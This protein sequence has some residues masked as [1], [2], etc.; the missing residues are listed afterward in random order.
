MITISGRHIRNAMVERRRMKRCRPLLRTVGALVSLQRGSPSVDGIGH[1]ALSLL[2][3]G[4]MP[5]DRAGM[6]I[7]AGVNP[8]ARS[9]PSS[10]FSAH[11]ITSSSF[12]LPCVNFEIITVLIA[13]LYIWAPTS[14]R[15]GA[16]NIEVCSSPRGG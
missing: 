14:E 8:Q 13:W 4:C 16:P 3:G 6:Q 10:S 2:A 1:Q 5:A 11:L 15:A 12:S 7:V 9:V